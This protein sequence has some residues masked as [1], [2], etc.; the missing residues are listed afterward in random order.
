MLLSGT[1]L[2]IETGEYHFCWRI[3]ITDY[4]FY[5]SV[6]YCTFPGSSTSILPVM[7]QTILCFSEVSHILLL[8]L[9]I[10][11][12]QKNLLNILNLYL[13]C[14]IFLRSIQLPYLSMGEMFWYDK[15]VGFEFKCVLLQ[16]KFMPLLP[17]VLFFTDYIIKQTNCLPKKLQ[18]WLP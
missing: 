4:I 7:Y 15:L 8:M 5:Q 2:L 10:I 16:T 18:T 6:F 3:I 1:L 14:L 17:L 9:C 12:G 11:M 13:S